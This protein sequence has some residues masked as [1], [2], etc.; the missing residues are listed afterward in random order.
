MSIAVSSWV[1]NNSPT[2]G[3]EKL[4]LLALADF[5]NDAG[6]CWPSISTI[7]KRCGLDRRYVISILHQLE[8]GGHI[9]VERR[10]RQSN[11][12]TLGGVVN[13]TPPAQEQEVRQASPPGEVDNTTHNEAGSTRVVRPASPESSINHQKE[14]SKEP[15]INPANPQAGRQQQPQP[16]T[17]GQRLVLDTFGAKRYANGV[18]KDLVAQLEQAYGLAKLHEAVKWAA[19]KGFRLGQALANIEKALPNWDQP[20]NELRSSA[21]NGGVRALIKGGRNNGEPNG[22]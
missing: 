7:A 5:A 15:P 4:V 21:A 16:L 10:G 9:Q 14:P 20:K 6:R 13:R 8:E 3:S 12:Y 18:Q 11:L 1:W 19:K 17:A 2:K 22:S